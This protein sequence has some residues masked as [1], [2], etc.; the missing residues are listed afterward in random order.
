MRFFK[1]TLEYDGTDFAGF[2]YQVGQQS[3]QAEVEAGLER[4]VGQPTRIAGAGRTDAGVHALGQVIG[5]K[6][7][8]RIPADR[9]VPA[10]NSVLPADIS[11]A[12]AL[13]VGEEFHARFSAKSRA[14]VYVLLNRPARSAVFGRYAAHC[15][16]ALDLCSMKQASEMLVG[17]HDFAA[18]AND[19]R[20]VRSTV[21]TVHTCRV[22]PAGPFVL[23]RVEANAFLKGMVRNIV[24]TLL[25]VGTGKRAPEDIAAITESRDR[26][27]AGP[28]APARGLCLVRVRY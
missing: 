1:V 19:V 6:A 7:E 27:Q 17:T 28:S 13:E 10:L 16:H 9:L 26:A 20:E 11:A 18:W 24:G 3:V 15:P 5:F 14:Y 25:E 12:R 4:L 2:Q 23:V 21:R 22:R 8:T